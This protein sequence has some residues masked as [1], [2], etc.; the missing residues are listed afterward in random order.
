MNLG[1]I[2]TENRNGLIVNTRVTLATAHLSAMRRSRLGEEIPDGSNC[3]TLGA[4]RAYDTAD[5]VE[6]MRELRVT[7]HVAENDTNRRSAIDPRTTSESGCA[8]GQ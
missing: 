5:F 1:Y 3:V 2:L 6:Q 7:P 4:D 8:I